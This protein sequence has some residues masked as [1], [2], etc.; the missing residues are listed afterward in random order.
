MD[1][2]LTLREKRLLVAGFRCGSRTAVVYD[3]SVM[4]ERKTAKSNSFYKMLRLLDF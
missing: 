1:C 4:I 2:G 3:V